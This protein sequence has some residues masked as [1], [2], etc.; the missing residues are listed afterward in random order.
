MVGLKIPY[1]ASIASIRLKF[2]IT[3]PKCL[4]YNKRNVTS[5]R[6]FLLKGDLI[7]VKICY[8]NFKIVVNVIN[9][10]IL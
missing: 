9:K 4:L 10:D 8:I 1:H 2:R 7:Y 5:H 3:L 6:F